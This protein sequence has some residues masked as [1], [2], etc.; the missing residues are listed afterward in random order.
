M[1]HHFESGTQVIQ[2]STIAR[3]EYRP[4]PKTGFFF[5]CVFVAA[6]GAL[7]WL[8]AILTR[9][10]A[11]AMDGVTRLLFTAVPIRLF[12]WTLAAVFLL[13][14]IRIVQKSMSKRPTLTISDS[15]LG[16]PDGRVLPWQ[17]V[18]SAQS[19]Q[20]NLEIRIA[21]GP[22][23]SE[24]VSGNVTRRGRFSRKP[25]QDTIRVSAFDLGADPSAVAATIA[26]ALKHGQRG[27]P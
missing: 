1:A 8:G 25:S 4:S 5:A 18:A 3:A 20:G 24:G 26:S 17:S 23:G 27:P 2:D 13:F 15:G 6:A 16:L 21:R 22:A 14:G 12:A 7:L 11:A 9:D 19:T 10:S